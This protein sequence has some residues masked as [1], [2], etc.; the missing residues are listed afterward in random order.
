MAKQIIVRFFQESEFAKEPTQATQGSAGYDLFAAEAMAILPRNCE[1]V[2]IDFRWSIPK[3]F[4]GKIYPR[5][6]LVKNMI[7]VDAG[8]IDSDYRGIVHMLIVNHSNKAFTIRTGDRVAQVV[9][10]EHYNVLFKKVDKKEFLGITKRGEDGFGSSGISEIKKTRTDTIIEEQ[11]KCFDES[12]FQISNFSKAGILQI[13]EN[14]KDD[15]QIIEEEAIMKIDNDVV[16]H[17]KV[18]I[19]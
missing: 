9:F 5:S 3:G 15:V 17:E 2:S 13:V 1:T 8:L 4:Y 14:S 6:S 16:V 19:D 12:V 10:V 18:T 7:T 11:Q